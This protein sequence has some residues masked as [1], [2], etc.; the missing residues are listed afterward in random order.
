[1]A[2]KVYI[3]LPISHFD[4]DE[5]KAYAKEKE[6]FLQHFFEVVNPFDN[7]VP[8][9]AHWSVHMRKDMKM[10]LECDTIY[11]CK[12]WEM[13]KGCKLEFDVATSCGL[14]VMYEEVMWAPDIKTDKK[15]EL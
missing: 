7:D 13:S 9:D 8:G 14:S 4:L 2:K 10:L 3:S 1:M 15:D 11:M 12:G 6:K 5:R